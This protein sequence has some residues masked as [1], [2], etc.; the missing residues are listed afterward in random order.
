MTT[1]NVYNM[2][3]TWNNGATVFTAIKVNVTDTASDAASLLMDLQVG[4]SSKFSVGKGGAVNASGNVSSAGGLIAGTVGTFIAFSAS[5]S[6][7]C[8]SNGVLELTNAA[9]NDFGRLQL[10]GT[11]SSFP[12]LKRS[13]ASLQAR[14]ADDSGFGVMQAKLTTDTN[15]TTGLTGGV[16][17]ATTNASIVIFD[18]AGQAYRVPCII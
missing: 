16:L 4:G 17:A 12:S 1:S 2:A 10:G 5:S 14:L 3:D 15:A 11:T 18:G 9:A 6:I 13:G 7:Y 8:P